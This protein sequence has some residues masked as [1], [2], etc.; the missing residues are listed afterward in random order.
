MQW[1][2]KKESASIPNGRSGDENEARESRSKNPCNRCDVV[3]GRKGGSDLN[4]K[5]SCHELDVAA[6]DARSNTLAVGV[7]GVEISIVRAGKQLMDLRFA[8][9]RT[10]LPESRMPMTRGIARERRVP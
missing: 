2:P 7:S 1:Q 3:V 5:C 6:L 4:E 9:A 10:I 8:G